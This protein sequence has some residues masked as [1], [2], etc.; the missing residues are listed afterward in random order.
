[1]MAL[2]RRERRPRLRIRSACDV[3]ILFLQDL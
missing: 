1:L 3:F 2:A